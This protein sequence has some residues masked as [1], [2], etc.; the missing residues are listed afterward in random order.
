MQILDLTHTISSAMPGW[1]GT[2]PVWLEP[3]C[4]LEKDGSRETSVQLYSHTGTHL[5]APAHLLE[6]GVT[7]D[8]L[9]PSQYVGKAVVLDCQNR[10][11]ITL[12]M[13]QSYTPQFHQAEFVLLYTGWS[14]Y[15]KTQE[16]YD[17]FPILTP[18]A[19]NY[20]AS[21]RLKGLGI[22]A[23]S[24]DGV[25][26]AEC[27]IHRIL[28]HSGMILLENLRNLRGLC[29][30]E[31]FLIAAPLKLRNADGAPARVFALL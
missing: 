23:I 24:F 5:D 20:L 26:D 31:F 17:N 22:D 29:G 13:L 19:A 25:T 18:D 14:R 9:P 30:R 15:W 4:E 7:L 12:A 16:Y 8:A 11:A 2:P 3:L 27:P 10:K 28:L 6:N 1:P 21:L